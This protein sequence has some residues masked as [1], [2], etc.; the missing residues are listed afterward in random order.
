M[1]VWTLPQQSLKKSIDYCIDYCI[2]FGVSCSYIVEIQFVL[3][4]ILSS[5]QVRKTSANKLY[6]TLLM[7]DE[8]VPEEN[9]DQ[10]QTLLGDTQW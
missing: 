7:F 5:F 3:S 4:L 1:A 10:I 2:V 9:L 6:E 8:Y